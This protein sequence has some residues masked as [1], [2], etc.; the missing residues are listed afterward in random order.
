[1]GVNLKGSAKSSVYLSHVRADHADQQAVSRTWAQ[2][3]HTCM[4]S[5]AHSSSTRLLKSMASLSSP[6]ASAAACKH[7]HINININNVI[8]IIIII[9]II[10]IFIGIY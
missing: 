3:S 2:P 9:I 10:D 1:M 7:H 8:I 6:I 4:R 5:R